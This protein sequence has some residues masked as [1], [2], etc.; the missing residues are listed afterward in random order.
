MVKSLPTVCRWPNVCYWIGQLTANGTSRCVVF[1][2]GSYCVIRLL[3]DNKSWQS[4]GFLT[5]PQYFEHTCT[6][7]GWK[8]RLKCTPCYLQLMEFF[9][10][11]YVYKLYPHNPH[12]SNLMR[13]MWVKS[14][15]ASQI[16][17][18]SPQTP[19]V[20][21]LKQN[22]TE[23]TESFVALWPAGGVTGIFISADCSAC[24]VTDWVHDTFCN[25]LHLT[26]TVSLLILVSILFNTAL[27]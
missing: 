16:P 14:Q 3:T 6:F 19:N 18:A 11:I 26:S 23:I 8:Q 25:E 12:T 17:L 7:L 4:F 15:N 24:W 20:L 13:G 10:S 1:L 2:K 5:G 27:N 9:Y 22:F 21:H